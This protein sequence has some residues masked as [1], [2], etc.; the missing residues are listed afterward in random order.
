MDDLNDYLVL[1]VTEGS[2][3][4]LWR[5]PGVCEQ[6]DELLGFTTTLLPS[7]AKKPWDG[8]FSVTPKHSGRR[9]GSEDS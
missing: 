5:Q 4:S 1:R 6:V 7:V 2:Q 3:S 8:Q 9:G